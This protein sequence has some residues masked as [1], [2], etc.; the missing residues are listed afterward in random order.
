M[1]VLLN[2]LELPITWTLPSGL[3]IKQSYLETKSTSIAPFMHSKIKLNLKVTVKDK[4]DKKKQ[5]RALMP[6]LIHSL[7]ATSLSLLYEQFYI[8][9]DINDPT[10]FFSV[11][12][13]FG[14]TC[15][16]VFRLKTILASVYT[17]LYSRDPYLC[18]F[19]QSLALANEANTHYKLDRVNRTVDLTHGKYTI[20][21]LEWVLNKKQLSSKI[22]KRIDCQHILI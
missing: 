21:D 3:T 9:S 7:D 18:K 6:N 15:E 8:N 12:D 13:C 14:T 20:H 2:L 10:Q 1:A 16:K 11:H 22:I 5:V 4:F 17:D 19:D